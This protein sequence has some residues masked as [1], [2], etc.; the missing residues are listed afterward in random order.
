MNQPDFILINRA[1]L[2]D[3]TI[4]TIDN[5]TLQTDLLLD[6]RDSCQDE[7]ELIDQE[8]YNRWLSMREDIELMEQFNSLS[9]YQLF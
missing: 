9:H 3:H 7:V 8:L 5:D 6:I 1:N 4:I 2:L